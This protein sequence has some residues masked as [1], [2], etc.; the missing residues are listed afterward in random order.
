MVSQVLKVRQDRQGLQGHLGSED[1]QGLLGQTENQGTL[2][3]QVSVVLRVTQ[4]YQAQK[5]TLEWEAL[6]VS[7]VLWARQE[8]REYLDTMVRQVQEVSLEYQVPEA[9]LGHQV[10]QESLDLRV[11]LE[12]QVLLAQ[13]V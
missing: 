2:G 7:K 10:F 12:T 11:T 3:N 8:Q 13:L 6:L 9:P 4:G 1:Q 5:V